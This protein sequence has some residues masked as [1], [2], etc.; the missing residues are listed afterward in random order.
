MNKSSNK[1]NLHMARS[2]SGCNT[3]VDND[4][5]ATYR[6]IT[7]KRRRR[8]RRRQFLMEGFGVNSKLEY[9]NSDNNELDLECR[10]CKGY[11]GYDLF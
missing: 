10:W 4:N 8:R 7:S 9:A 1:N 2:I 11:S 3:L 5:V 6:A